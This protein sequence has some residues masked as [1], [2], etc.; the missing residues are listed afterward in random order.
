MSNNIEIW[1]QTEYPNILVSSFGNFIREN[2]KR[3]IKGTIKHN[4]KVI[5]LGKSKSISLHVLVAKA[6]PE[7]CG[8]WFDGCHVHHKNFNKLDNRAENLI[9]LTPTEHSKLHYETHTDLFKK[10][11]EKRSLA[12]K[13]ALTGRRAIEKHKPV[14]QLDKDGCFIKLWACGADISKDLGKSQ[15]NI[16]SCC[17][18]KLKTTYGYIWKYCTTE[19]YLISILNKSFK[20]RGLKTRKD[21]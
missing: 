9:I 7:I 1:K 3:E 2:Y 18:G 15:G 16:S 17:E 19:N 11:S 20:E 10:P 8:E 13:K 14:L 21:G 12:I 6:F 5:S 4:Y